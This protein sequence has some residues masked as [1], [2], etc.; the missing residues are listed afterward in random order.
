M[1]NDPGYMCYHKQKLPCPLV[2][3]C[4]GLPCPLHVL[5]YTRATLKELPFWNVFVVKLLRMCICIFYFYVWSEF[6]GQTWV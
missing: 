4:P 3:C 2:G 6:V 5:L 1:P